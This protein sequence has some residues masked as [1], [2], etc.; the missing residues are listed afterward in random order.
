M[1]VPALAA[2]P[3]LV[4]FAEAAGIVVAG[5]ATAAGIDTLSKKVEEYVEENPEQSQKILAMIMPAQGI[6]N[7]LKNESDDGEEVSETEEVAESESGSTK[8]MVLEELNKKTGNYSD[9]NATGNYASGR[10][11]IIGRLKR[12]G[13]IRQDNDPNYDP[14]KKYKG[15]TKF[16][17]KKYADGGIMGSDKTYH[18]VRD[19]FM[20]MDSESMEY[21]NGG[22]VGSMM[23][24][25]SFKGGGADMGATDRAQERADRG[26]GSTA[27]AEDKSTQQ[28]TDNNNRVTGNNTFMPTVNPNEI[29]KEEINKKLLSKFPTS[30]DNNQILFNNMKKYQTLNKNLPFDFISRFQLPKTKTKNIFTNNLTDLNLLYPDIKIEDEYGII[31]ADKAKSLIDR[32]VVEQTISPV[33]GLNLTK[34][35]NTTGDLSN[36]SG[37]YT[38]GDFSFNSPNI[39]EGILNSGFNYNLGDLNLS[40]G[41]NTNDSTINDSKLGFNYDNDSL[42]GSTYRDN[43][44]GY[45]TNKLGV[46]K[47]FNIGDNFKVGLDGSYQEDKFKDGSY[48]NADLTPSLTYNDG[49]FN[50]NLSKEIVEG[51]T[52]P[53]LGIGFQKN[54]FYANAN[55]LLSEDRTGTIGYKKE[56]GN[57][58]SDLQFSIGAEKNLFDDNYTGGLF[59]K[60]IFKDGGRVNYNQGSNWWDTLDSQGMGVYNSMKRGG[61]NDAAIQSQLSMLGYYDPNTTPP[62][63]TPDTTPGQTIGYQGGDNFSPYNP[64]PNSIKSFKVDSRVGAANEADIRNRQLTS[65][66]INDPF[67]DEISLSGAYY[68]DMPTDTSNLIGK[69]SML[70]KAKQGLSGIVGNVKGLMDSPIG[71]AIGFAMN[72]VMGGLKGIASML[73]NVMPI[74]QRSIQENI[75]GN[76]GVAVND[77]GQIVS[78]GD[79]DDPNNVMAGYNLNRMTPA[80]FKKRI[81]KIRNRAMPQT[82][83]SA[84]RIKSIKEAQR[85][86]ELGEKLKEERLLEKQLQR[87]QKEIDRKGYQ[88]YGQGGADQATQNSYQGSDGNYAGSSAQDYDTPD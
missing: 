85:R 67:A 2:I 11:R 41:V 30:V 19:Q 54:G 42:T 17:K 27:P 43:D 44:Y 3:I 24:R 79:Y 84:N 32:A 73:G 5:V 77:I 58:E 57:P 21:A 48:Y 15:Y 49:T 34:S 14:D 36:T 86:F 46:D 28:Q 63:S 45:T 40:A 82:I 18:Q 9:P 76:M 29:I 59:G 75:M 23:K 16:Y 22:G 8:D 71:N 20:P 4:S 37:N 68:G 6:A 64:D 80:T 52:Q 56:I 33:D 81:D 13:K 70:G 87:A 69:Q 60:Y 31:N 88:D 74:N 35:I 53:S 10:G 1:P 39:E 38:L 7:I 72:P 55:N 26:Y 25:K 78:T 50:A 65:M 61:H 12:E 83:A 51:G 66:G 47:T 62:D